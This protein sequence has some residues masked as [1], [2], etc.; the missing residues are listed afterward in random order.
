[1]DR[2]RFFKDGMKDVARE[3]LQTPVGKA[4]D[5]QL[6][7]VSNLLAPQFFE[8]PAPEQEPV[9]P[10]NWRRLARP[11]GALPPAQ[12]EKKCTRCADCIVAC[13]YGVL[14]QMGPATGPLMDP[15]LNAC[16][17][18]PDTPC[19]DACE[20]GALVPL[21]KKAN[22]QF[23]LAVINDRLCRNHESRRPADRR[24]ALCKICVREC[25]VSGAIQLDPF[26]PAVSQD[27]TGCG[28]CVHACPTQAIRV[29]VF[30]PGKKP[31]LK[32]RSPQR[33]NSR[34]AGRTAS[35]K[36]VK[37]KRKKKT[38]RK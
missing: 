10:Q 18:C 9:P 11:P 14:F 29:D 30:A 16:R 25:P 33:S 15:N 12:F 34:S 24:A 37:P 3:V 17:L 32:K 19:I 4:L 8:M 20:T 38:P 13:P 35:K 36:S 27:C 7:A 22:P 23:G 5:R 21:A 31:R 6:Q 2:R 28:Q 26:L 1:M